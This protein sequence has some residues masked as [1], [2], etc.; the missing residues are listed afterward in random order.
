MESAVSIA[1]GMKKTLLYIGR[2]GGSH[3]CYEWG[4]HHY[5]EHSHF[6]KGENAD[7]WRGYRLYESFQIQ[8]KHHVHRDW[9][10][11]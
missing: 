9:D 4:R 10:S 2:K 5:C 3:T 1:S 8:K 11:S 6:G 7:E